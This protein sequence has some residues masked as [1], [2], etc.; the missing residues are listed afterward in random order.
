MKVKE[1]RTTSS[2]GGQ[3]GSKGTAFANIPADF[4]LELGKHYGDGESKYPSDPDG[5]PNFWKGYDI[6]LNI[7]ALF[8]HLYAWLDGEDNIPD[9]GTDDPTIG[10]NHLMAVV[11]HAIDMWRK[12]GTEWDTRPAVA[13]TNREM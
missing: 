8:R 1:I 4:M 11:W 6:R 3:K 12:Q 5:F 2:T 13:E 10:N 9:D 7:E